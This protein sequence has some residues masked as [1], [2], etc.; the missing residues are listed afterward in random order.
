MAGID[1]EAFVA[2]YPRIWH[3]AEADSWESV[4]RHGLL[5]TSALLDRFEV[6]GEER[7]ALESA[8]RP[9]SVTISHPVHGTATIRDNIPLLEKVLERT[10]V[11][12]TAREWYEALNRRVFFWVS[13]PRLERLRSA[14][15]Y[16][17]R[18][19]D[20]LEV[21]TAALLAR[22]IERVALSPINS[23]ATHPGAQF[24]RGAETFQPMHR[25]P[26][27]TRLAKNRKEPVVELAVD[28]GVPDIED[29]VIA[30]E[31]Q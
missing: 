12:M 3:M 5:S 22:H 2:R 11:G 13:Q 8:R 6:D 4:C 1:P 14:P 18:E 27:A 9:R 26:W 29:V 21:D 19:H 31:R 28:Y 15:A 23:G 10:L 24:T 16:R 30:V 25:Y 17:D 20:V 7:V